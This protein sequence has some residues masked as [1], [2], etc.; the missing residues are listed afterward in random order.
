MKPMA[1]KLNEFTGSETPLY[2]R[3]PAHDYTTKEPTLENRCILPG[4]EK[5]TNKIKQ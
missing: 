4:I 2:C 5:N 3:T 1:L